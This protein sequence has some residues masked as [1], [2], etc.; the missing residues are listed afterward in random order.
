MNSRLIQ[1]T[2]IISRPTIITLIVILSVFFTSCQSS[3]NAFNI[4]KGAPPNGKIIVKTTKYHYF[5]GTT[6]GSDDQPD[7]EIQK[8]AG[9]ST[10]NYTIVEYSSFVDILVT[11]GTIGIVSPTSI[12]IIK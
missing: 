6:S 10:R 9:R 7:F 5:W 3:Y 1:L 8:L 2:S 4:G 11:I 12:E